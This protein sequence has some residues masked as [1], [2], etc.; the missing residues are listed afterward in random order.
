MHPDFVATV[1]QN[2]AIVTQDVYVAQRGPKLRGCALASARMSNEELSAAAAVYQTATVKL[3]ASAS[4]QPMCD[5]QFVNWVLERVDDLVFVETGSVQVH[6]RARKI[7]QSA[8]AA[9]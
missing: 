3:D 5:Q 8:R 1:T 4:S 6:M 9:I 2:D 7:V